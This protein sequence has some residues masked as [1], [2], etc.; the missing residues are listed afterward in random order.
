[1][2]GWQ[3]IENR[4]PAR[5]DATGLNR[6]RSAQPDDY[7]PRDLPPRLRSHLMDSLFVARAARE[8]HRDVRAIHSLSTSF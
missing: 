5:R 3:A 7:L 1:M 4:R 6:I 8:I 2:N